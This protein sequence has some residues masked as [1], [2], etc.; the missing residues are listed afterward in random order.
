[1][2]GPQEVDFHSLR[3]SSWAVTNGES[4]DARVRVTSVRSGVGRET[5]LTG[6]PPP[7]WLHEGNHAARRYGTRRTAFAHPC[8]RRT[9]EDRNGSGFCLREIY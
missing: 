9:G 1:V 5:W 2:V 8:H 7:P 4:F 6:Y 3:S